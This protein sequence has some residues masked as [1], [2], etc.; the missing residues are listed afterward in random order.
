M[1]LYTDGC[2]K[3]IVIERKLNEKGVQFEICDS[4]E[5]FERLGYTDLPMLVSDNNIEMDFS[6]ALMWLHSF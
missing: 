2:P 3:G 5:E 4:K 6:K 1:I